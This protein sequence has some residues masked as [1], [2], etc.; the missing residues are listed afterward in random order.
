MSFGRNYRATM[1]AAQVNVHSCSTFKGPCTFQEIQADLVT[2]TC[3]SLTTTRA[4]APARRWNITLFGSISM[5][6]SIA[7]LN[8]DSTLFYLYIPSYGTPT[9]L[10]VKLACRVLMGVY[11][12]FLVATRYYC[13]VKHLADAL[14]RYD[15]HVTSTAVRFDILVGEP[16]SLVVANPFV[17][18]FF[19]VDIWASAEY[20]G[21]ACLRVSQ[22]STWYKFMLG[23][24][25]FGRMMWFSAAGLLLLNVWLCCS[26]FKLRKFQPVDVMYLTMA[27]FT[28]GPVAVYVQ[29]LI[30]AAVEMYTYMFGALAT[31]DPTT[32]AVATIDCTFS[33]A[34]F[35][36]TMCI[37]PVA[38]G[39]S[40]VCATSAA[41]VTVQRVRRASSSLTSSGPHHRIVVEGPHHYEESR[42]NFND[43][44]QRLSL[45]F[46]HDGRVTDGVCY[47]GS[48][49][50]L[51]NLYSTAQV[52]RTI[53]QRGTDCY[54]FGYNSSNA[55]V[56][57]T[58]VSLVSHINLPPL[59][60]VVPHNNAVEHTTDHSTT[61]A[62]GRIV[63]SG[64]R[65][66]GGTPSIILRRGVDGS[67]WV[68]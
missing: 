22:L 16:T 56:E 18:A 17:C 35:S 10:Q 2:A 54:V 43:Y 47:G 5:S 38:F 36:I 57:I 12:L 45:W 27:S 31:T 7:W 24:L 49:Y 66:I 25:S 48:A 20:V 37:V 46:C 4:A 8:A 19:I 14:K 34:I 63:F 21:L 61:C 13:H 67:P 53:N 40:T 55:L 62:V 33:L 50:R 41:R 1:S 64:R 23:L 44:K 39:Y 15:M 11:M 28:M 51:F 52:N 42:F 29:G 3:S 59:A 6:T 26:T 32:G 58:R 30:P 68:A 65:D 9:L 60:R